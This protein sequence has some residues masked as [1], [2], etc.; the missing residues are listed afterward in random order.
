MRHIIEVHYADRITEYTLDQP[1]TTIGRSA[2]NMILL[3]ST[4]VSRHHARL[5]LIND[6][7][8]VIDLGS[9]NHA[10][11]ELI[12]DELFVIDLG[13]SNGTLVN[14]SEIQPMSPFLIKEGDQVIIADYTLIVGPTLSELEAQPSIVDMVSTRDHIQ[15]Q[16]QKPAVYQEASIPVKGREPLAKKLGISRALIVKWVITLVLSAIIGGAIG[17][18]NTESTAQ[19]YP[20]TGQ[21]DILAELGEPPL[22]VL[23]DGPLKPGGDIHR[24]ECW[25]YPGS[26]VR[27]SFANGYLLDRF[28]QDL[29]A[30]SSWGTNV[31]NPC[32][33]DHT[34]TFEDVQLL[35]GEQGI[36]IDEYVCNVFEG[37]KAYYF[38]NNRLLI[39]FID[40]HFF[41]AE[42]Y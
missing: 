23:T 15:Q 17:F 18:F 7:L 27:I 32:S 4:Q 24:M 28:E 41:Y 2:D 12:N 22:W 40:G 13:S 10:R 20:S 31:F 38:S 3:D 39:T 9:S 29:N 14:S 6:E 8:F 42:T 19:T 36:C 33:L 1:T 37:N 34:M 21:Q 16:F 35:L 26:D 5:E 30:E 25:I 11:L